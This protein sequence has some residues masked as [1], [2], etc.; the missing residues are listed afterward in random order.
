MTPEDSRTTN[1][2]H[3]I[4]VEIGNTNMAA[5]N[6]K[7]HQN[8]NIQHKQSCV[9]FIHST[10]QIIYIY[11][12]KTGQHNPL[13]KIILSSKKNKIHGGMIETEC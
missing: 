4:G 12:P 6:G 13:K 1:K 10:L 5:A 2:P 3:V 7:A 8:A 11:S 9:I